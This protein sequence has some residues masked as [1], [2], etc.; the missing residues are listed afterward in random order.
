M[1]YTQI[2]HQN[3]IKKCQSNQIYIY[4]QHATLPKGALAKFYLSTTFGLHFMISSVVPTRSSNFYAY[5]ITK[6]ETLASNELLS[7]LL[8]VSHLI[9]RY[10]VYPLF[11]CFINHFM[12]CTPWE[13]PLKECL[14][15]WHFLGP[16]FQSFFSTLGSVFHVFCP[17]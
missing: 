3:L 6:V 16:I 9:A 5:L 7:V 10:R 17:L 8:K 12:W 2:C 13:S 4:S 11:V 1:L 14:G 15:V